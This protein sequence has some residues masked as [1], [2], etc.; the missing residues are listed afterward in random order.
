MFV[1]ES[2]AGPYLLVASVV[3]PADLG[4]ARGA[5]RA[6][7][8]PKQSRIHMKTETDGRRRTILSAFE[9]AGLR[10]TIYRAVGYKTN[11]AARE[12]CIDKLVRPLAFEPTARVTFECDESQDARDRQQLFRLVRE[13][14]CTERVQYEHRLA[15]AEPLLA[16]PDAIGW[17]YARGGDF[18]S[19][20]MPLVT[21]I[22]DV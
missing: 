22:V 12:A 10:A 3:L 14:R 19:R 9:R 16:V 2:K 15:A 7:H 21:K 18:R 13:L 20:A 1:D 8:L 11:I 4:A 6:L 5:V 17:A